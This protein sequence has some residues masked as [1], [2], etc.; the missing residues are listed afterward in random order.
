MEP[1][2]SPC[3]LDLIR[4]YHQIPVEPSDVPK[5]AITTPFGLFEFV[6]IPFGLRNAA[7]TF[8]RFIDQVLHGLHFT[9]AYIDDV[10]ITSKSPAEYQQHLHTVL[11]RFQE[12]GILIN[13]A[14]CE[15]GVSELSFSV[16]MWI[17]MAYDL[18]RNEYLLSEIFL[19]PLLSVSLEFL[20]LVNFYRRFIAHCAHILKPL[21]EMLSSSHGKTPLQWSDD[22]TAAFA[23]I[24][25]TLA[26]ALLLYHPKPDAPTCI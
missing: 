15:F 14:K 25:D 22:A 24:K 7:Q 1:P 3:K 12:H 19:N 17:S 18:W 4:A 6:R 10:L 20:G 13:P 23:V 2:F 26:K 11:E 8:Q 16:I 21:H 5:T 9:F